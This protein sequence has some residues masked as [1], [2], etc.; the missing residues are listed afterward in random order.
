MKKLS[1]VELLVLMD[2][3]TTMIP[4]IVPFA[5]QLVL[6]VK[7]Q[8]FARGVKWGTFWKQIPLL[9]IL[10]VFVVK[11]TVKFADKTTNASSALGILFLIIYNIME[12]ACRHAQQGS[13]KVKFQIPIQELSMRALTVLVP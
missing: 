8:T 7:R 6:H 1:H 4:G 5:P 2:I 3:T 12:H 9:G 11:L 10:R 13:T